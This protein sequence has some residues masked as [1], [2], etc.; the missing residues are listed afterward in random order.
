MTFTHIVKLYT[1][2]G[3]LL[4]MLL[5]ALCGVLMFTIFSWLYIQRYSQY[6]YE[7]SNDEGVAS[8]SEALRV[9]IVFGGGIEE[10]QPKPL[11]Q[12]RLDTAYELYEKGAVDIVLVSGDNRFSHYNEPEVMKNYLIEKKGMNPENVYA[13]FA[14]RSTY[15]TCERAVRIFAVKKA[16]L[17]SETTHLTR[18]V[19][20]CRHFGIE[21]YGVSSDGKAA[22]NLR[23]SQ[24]LREIF[25]RNKAIINAYFIGEQ[26]VL[27]EPEPL[28]FYDGNGY[29]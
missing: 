3:N 9:A 13:D 26:T 12:D 4:S 20:L 10:N 25:A 29:F 11:L 15:E 2:K 23:F 14:G 21:A 19:F 24:Q 5:L 28:P 17:V 1:S 7:N 27:G 18:A 22:S 6:V 16:F 8:L